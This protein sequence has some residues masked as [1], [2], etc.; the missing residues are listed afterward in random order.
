MFKT[1][2]S[3]SPSPAKF[4]PLLFA[5]DWER[6]VETAATLGYDAVEFS[7]RAPD[8]DLLNAIG[9]A[10]RARGLAVSAI[11]TG[12]SY[13]N[14]GLSLTSGEPDVQARLL[15]RMKAFID[16]AAGWGGLLIIGGVR[17]V[18]T[19][20]AMTCPDQR[21]RAQEAVRSY[22]EYAAPRGVSLA[23]EPINRY[24]TNFINTIDEALQFLADVGSPN[25]LVLADTFHMNIEEISLSGSLMEAGSKLGYVHFADSNRHAPG[26][27]HVDFR[28]LARVLTLIGYTGY[29]GAEI[30]P[31]PDSATA[32]RLAIEYFRAL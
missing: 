26:Q 20:D 5:G 29:L 15:D 1:T 18:L 12:Q 27:G 14:D 24:E 22:A 9:E 32:A 23:I 30:L 21:R 6:G 25:L 28:E 16:F 13:Y 19:G 4:A 31:L 7:L 2:L 10:V 11:A 8:A 17:G 3:I